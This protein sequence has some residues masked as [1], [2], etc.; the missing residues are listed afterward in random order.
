MCSYLLA[1]TDKNA[2]LNPVQLQMTQCRSESKQR[3]LSSVVAIELTYWVVDSVWRFRSAEHCSSIVFPSNRSTIDNK[4]FITAKG[5]KVAEGRIDR[6]QPGI[7]SV[8]DLADVGVDDGTW[9]AGYGP[10]AK[11]NGKINKVLIEQKK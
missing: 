9:V 7:F 4:I 1:A 11:F 3:M 6:T 2:D 10:S 8:D 5:S